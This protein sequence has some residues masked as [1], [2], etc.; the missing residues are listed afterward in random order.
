MIPKVRNV[1][2]V[3]LENQLSE[4][5]AFK[6]KSVIFHKYIQYVLLQQNASY[7]ILK[8]TYVDKDLKLIGPS[9]EE[10]S[11][12]TEDLVK[13]GINLEMI[14]LEPDLEYWVVGIS[15]NKSV[16]PCRMN[17]EFK[18]SEKPLDILPYIVQTGAD[19]VLFSE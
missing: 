7:R 14:L 2:T 5:S 10:I 17:I 3:I 8:T 18:L 13:S 19:H 16:N 12:L 11:D 6:F 1:E 4:Q 15:F 9:Y